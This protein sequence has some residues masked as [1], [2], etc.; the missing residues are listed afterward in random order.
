MSQND[1]QTAPTSIQVPTFSLPPSKLLS[2]ESLMALM[3]QKQAQAQAQAEYERA[4]NALEVEGDSADKAVTKAEKIQHERDEFYTSQQYKRLTQRYAV[5]LE[6]VMMA[7]VYTEH[8][9]PEEGVS[10]DNETRVL[11]NLHGG[12]F[13]TGSRTISHLE[14]IPIA[15]VAKI[16]VISVDYRLAPDHQFPAAT[17]DTLAVYRELLNH[18]PADNIGIFGCSAGARLTAHAIARIQHEGLPMPA[19]VSMACAATGVWDEGD[20]WHWVKAISDYPLPPREAVSYFQEKDFTNPMAFPSLSDELMA[21]FPPSLLISATR[22]YS[23]S[24]VVSAHAQFVK[25]GVDTELHIWDGLEHVFLYNPELSESRD[26]YQ[27]VAR[28]FSRYLSR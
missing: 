7:G 6:P 19:A 18:Y 16:K 4:G 23:L 13:L 21:A 5:D 3:E 27:I 10:P 11:I 14:S 25:L 26:Y 9:V 17:D 12:S 1:K 20:S 8:F 22:D 15:A 2:S 28:F 24:P